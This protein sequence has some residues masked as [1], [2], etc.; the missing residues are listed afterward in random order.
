MS[1]LAQLTDD[2]AAAFTT[3][4][5][6]LDKAAE[7]KRELTADENT[8]YEAA[9]R[10][11][12]KKMGEIARERKMDERSKAIGAL[13]D[14]PA[15]G[16]TPE[17]RGA[18]PDQ[19]SDGKISIISKRAY[20][21][22]CRQGQ[23]ALNPDEVRQ[24]IQ[25]ASTLQADV[26]ILGG[27]MI[28][29]PEMLSVLIKAIDDQVFIR[30][31]ATVLQLTQSDSIGAPTFDK[32]VDDADW[33]SELSTGAQTD[34]NTGKRELRP[35]PLAKKVKMSNKLLRLAPGVESLVMQRLGYKFGITE[36]K[37]FMNGTGVDQPLGLFTPSSNGIPISQ[38]IT[39]GSTTT[40]LTPDSLIAALYGLKSAYRPRSNWLFHRYVI[41]SIRKMKDTVGQYLWQPALASGAP[42][43]ILERPF[44]E[45]EY[46]PS[47]FTTGQYIGM[48]GAFE[49]YWIVDALNLTVQRLVELYA[50]Q[51]STGFI[52]RKE[53]D[54]APVL[55]EAFQR[56]TLA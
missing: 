13:A 16:L 9:E 29:P 49:H 34:L 19:Q 43:T 38:D 12:D 36:E 35:H 33:T 42:G 28:P 25:R 24:I 27:F 23:G 44:I 45:S 55:G 40:A 37:V 50:E 22:W 30:S 48:I 20:E 5:G 26:N 53:L 10:D 39:E 1:R 47:T 3:M 18:N 2:S 8:S 17:N 11:Y 46:A 52:G 56:L 32:D 31:I 6:L 15:G 41:K 7:E 14:Q 21:T 4:R 51:N 54:G